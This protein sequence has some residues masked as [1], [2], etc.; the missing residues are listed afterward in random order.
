MV[1]RAFTISRFQPFHNGHYKTI[2]RMKKDGYKEIIIGIGSAEKS[3]RPDNPFTC[4]E[5][6]EMIHSVLRNEDFEH[7]FIIPVRD[8]DDYDL[9]VKHVVRL[10]PK[11]DVLYAG[12]P[13]IIELF[14]KAGYKVVKDERIVLTD[15]SKKAI[16]PINLSG[17]MIREMIVDN[18]EIWKRLV[19][20]EVYKKI[21]EFNGIERIKKLN[22]MLY[23]E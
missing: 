1:E 4:S 5:R 17:S 9:W 15:F 21:L 18:N 10:V 19:P 7:Y 14:K 23:Q 22:S 13:L 12:N 11:F 8:I 16:K 2:E 20:R 6:I 3:Y